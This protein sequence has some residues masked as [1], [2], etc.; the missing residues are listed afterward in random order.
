[1][2]IHKVTKFQDLTALENEWNDLVAR[3]V[4]SN[5]FLS[6]AWVKTWWRHFGGD[7]EM[8]VLLARYNGKLEG[9]APLM[10]TKRK[11]VR[12]IG[13]PIAD[14]ADFILS[15]RSAKVL[16]AFFKYLNTNKKLWDSVQLDEIPEDS[17]TLKLSG[18]ILR[19]E[20]YHFISFSNEC[21]ALDFG[22]DASQLGRLLRKKA[23]RR[24]IKSLGNLGVL[25]FKQITASAD[26]SKVLPIFFEQHKEI[27]KLRRNRSMFYDAVYQK[28][29]LDIARE[30]LPL[31]AVDIFVL[32]LDSRPIAVQYGFTWNGKHANYCQSY[33]PAFN[34]Y[35]PGTVII[36]L[37]VE[38]LVKKGLKEVDF[39]RGTEPYKTR[40]SNTRRCNY[41]I[42]LRKNAMSHVASK[43]Y[44]GIKERVMR[45]HRLHR[46]VNRFKSRLFYEIQRLREIIF[47]TGVPQHKLALQQPGLDPKI[48]KPRQKQDRREP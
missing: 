20:K 5:V 19:S 22:K 1:M 25:E 7:K 48:I 17:P 6:H 18:L 32:C 13:H 27:W 44:N 40:F 42:S 2:Q 23:L 21:M 36:K 39:T 28:F 10:I 3:S 11:V 41:S 47:F 8:L 26:A 33:D 29:F 35:S 4:N 16:G 46:L 30:L 9:I 34:R 14:Y 43:S 38:R 37:Y 45:N 31:Q 15:G 12:L 24:H